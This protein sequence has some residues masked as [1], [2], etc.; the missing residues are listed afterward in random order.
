MLLLI[1]WK[2]IHNHLRE[3]SILKRNNLWSDS[4][5]SS[6]C[7]RFLP[8]TGRQKANQFS[9]TNWGANWFLGLRNSFHYLSVL[10]QLKP[11]TVGFLSQSW[12][13]INEVILSVT[14]LFICNIYDDTVQFFL[15]FCSPQKCEL[16]WQLHCYSAHPNSI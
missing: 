3:K 9:A 1:T 12:H 16:I 7:Y 4:W 15:H 2:R 11:L 5:G 14:C 13:V 8:T 6:C 10:Y